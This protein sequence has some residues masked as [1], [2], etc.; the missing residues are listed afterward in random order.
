LLALYNQLRQERGG[1]GRIGLTYKFHHVGS[2]PGQRK[3]Q[4][5]M[6]A[7]GAPLHFPGEQ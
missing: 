7:F 3:N 6:A 2:T 1:L 5:A 4:N